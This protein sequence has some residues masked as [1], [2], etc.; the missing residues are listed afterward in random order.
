MGAV[1]GC[2]KKEG[3]SRL[4]STWDE[5]QKD[6]KRRSWRTCSVITELRT[7]LI[8]RRSCCWCTCM[9]RKRSKQCD[10]YC[11]I[12]VCRR[13]IRYSIKFSPFA[14]GH[15][16][17]ILAGKVL[18]LPCE[19]K[20]PEAVL[21]N[22]GKPGQGSGGRKETFSKILW[23]KGARSRYHSPP[24]ASWFGSKKVGAVSK[25][26]R[27]RKRLWFEFFSRPSYCS[28]Q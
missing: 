26:P 19:P 15:V 17:L 11:V 3:L 12:T 2:F 20:L 6:G 4:Y 1:V 7:N 18:P 5:K 10:T 14:N 27:R 22:G 16:I 13:G 8:R 23:S 24:M 9:T 25:V 28:Q 21:P